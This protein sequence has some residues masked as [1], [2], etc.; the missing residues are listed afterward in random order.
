MKNSKITLVSV[1]LL[2]GLFNFI[3][4]KAD[5]IY[6][7]GAGGYWNN[8]Y[9]WADSVVPTLVDSVFI[10]GPVEV[11][12]GNE[13]ASLTVKVSGDLFGEWWGGGYLTE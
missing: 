3:N 11:Q 10:V 1:L 12:P 13:C 9:T 7:T 4:V 2:L 6:S 8:P 5:I